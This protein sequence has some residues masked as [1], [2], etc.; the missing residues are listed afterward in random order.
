[1]EFIVAT[2]K[3]FK[4]ERGSPVPPCVR[5]AREG[6][7]FAWGHSTP[8]KSN[9]KTCSVCKY[10]MYCSKECQTT[11]WHTHHSSVCGAFAKHRDT[12]HAIY[13]NTCMF[14]DGNTWFATPQ[15]ASHTFRRFI[16]AQMRGIGALQGLIS[17]DDVNAMWRGV[18]MA[19]PINKYFLLRGA[20]AHPDTY[21]CTITQENLFIEAFH[22]G[23]IHPCVAREIVRMASEHVINT[24][25][26]PFAGNGIVPALVSL[27]AEEAHNMTVRAYRDASES[28]G[29]VDKRYFHPLETADCYGKEVY[30]VHDPAKTLVVVPAASD[31]YRTRA[32]HTM[33]NLY[34]LGF[35]NV[36]VLQEQATLEHTWGL[37][38]CLYESKKAFNPFAFK[39]SGCRVFDSI[40][41]AILDDIR[42]PSGLAAIAVLRSTCKLRT[43]I[44]R[45]DC[46]WYTRRNN[47]TDKQ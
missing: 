46:A 38:S 24:I 40:P 2:M 29:V 6:A 20:S 44:E 23:L 18:L 25:I 45:W 11:D 9:A 13:N 7:S 1:M 28:T 35:E 34:F 21:T 43:S 26:V 3:E 12:L 4:P 33:T 10:A 5:C 31:A 36:V 39:E 47:A 17:A 16:D 15:F 14:T 32:A 22:E 42:S 30:A 27:F 8:E 37:A 41:G 19:S